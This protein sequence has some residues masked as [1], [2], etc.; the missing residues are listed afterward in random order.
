MPY[1]IETTTPEMSSYI[2]PGQ[3]WPRTVS[4]R[5]VAT[6]EEAQREAWTIVAD[7]P[8]GADHSL[9][10]WRR[11]AANVPAEGGTI[12]PLPDGGVIEVRQVSWTSL[13]T[14]SGIDESSV[15]GSRPDSDIIPAFNA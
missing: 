11:D 15:P 6:L 14:M 5:A 8:T 3:P 2:E 4:R 10:E 7:S 1:I 12:G 13:R 9:M